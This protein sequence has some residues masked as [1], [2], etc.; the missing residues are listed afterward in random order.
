MRVEGLRKGASH[1]EKV[2]IFFEEISTIW[3]W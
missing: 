3:E 2:R 1:A